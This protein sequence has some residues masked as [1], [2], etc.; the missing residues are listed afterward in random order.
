MF[1][2]KSPWSLTAASLVWRSTD[3]VWAHV[4]FEEAKCERLAIEDLFA[5][6][7]LFLIVEDPNLRELWAWIG[8]ARPEFAVLV[9]APSMKIAVLVN[10]VTIIF[11]DAK[12]MELWSS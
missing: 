10:H 1:T 6:H 8:I 9:V 3:S 12:R 4:T 2:S 7:V 5:P 11:T